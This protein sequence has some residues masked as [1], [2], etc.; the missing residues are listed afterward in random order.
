[1]DRRAAKWALLVWSVLVLSASCGS[2]SGEA[3]SFETAEMGELPAADQSS[4]D[5]EWA[6]ETVVADKATVMSDLEDLQPWDDVYRVPK[7]SELL[8]GIEQGTIVVWPQV[9]VLEIQ[10]VNPDGDV[11][12]IRAE[13]AIF[14][15]AVTS[16]N[17]EFSHALEAGEPGR[18]VGMKPAADGSMASQ[19]LAR[20]AI[21]ADPGPAKYTKDGVSY[22]S[23][24]G[25]ISTTLAMQGDTIDVDF[26]ATSNNIDLSVTGDV[27]GMKA[28]G[29]VT[30]DP[31]AEDPDP[32]V[33]INFEGISANVTGKLSVD[34]GDWTRCRHTSDFLRDWTAQAGLGRG[35]WDP[36]LRNR[37]QRHRLPGRLPRRLKLRIKVVHRPSEVRAANR[38][39]FTDDERTENESTESEY[40]GY[41][42]NRGLSDG[43]RGRFPG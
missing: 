7:D 33:I 29:R 20:Q 42:R 28:D 16:A 38:F 41:R 30:V 14:S 25:D 18:A 17:I 3:P 39:V 13:N 12:E 2:N 24:S 31:E 22:T 34:G 36:Q 19:G 21:S 11:V 15:D 43:V 6:D 37:W 32:T 27:S 23:P 8:E 1:M 26:T 4:V 40:V 9:G 5:I 10:Q 35:L